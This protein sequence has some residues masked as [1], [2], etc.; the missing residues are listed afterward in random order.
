M[1]VRYNIDF[2]VAVYFSQSESFVY[3]IVVSSVFSL[4]S[5]MQ[6]D[7]GKEVHLTSSYF[8]FCAGVLNQK[9]L[10]IRTQKNKSG[11]EPINLKK[12]L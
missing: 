11:G 1:F 4:F 9:L 7:S 2:Q 6:L 3:Y 12:K 10:Y 5:W 8:L